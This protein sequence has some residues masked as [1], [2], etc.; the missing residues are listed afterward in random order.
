[1]VNECGVGTLMEEEK[2]ELVSVRMETRLRF[3]PMARLDR[4]PRAGNWKVFKTFSLIIED[5]YL[6]RC[7]YRI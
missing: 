4:K 3:A 1:M 5:R 2:D 7:T 6:G